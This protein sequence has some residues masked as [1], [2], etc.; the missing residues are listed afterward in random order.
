MKKFFEKE[1]VAWTF[2]TICITCAIAIGIAK[3]PKLVWD[4]AGVLS[5]STVKELKK[6]NKNWEDEYDTRIGFITADIDEG[7]ELVELAEDT[8]EELDLGD[9]DAVIAVSTE[10]NSYSLYAGDEFSTDFYKIWIEAFLEQ[11]EGKDRAKKID[12]VARELYGVLDEAFE[13][14]YD[15]QSV[16]ENPVLGYSISQGIQDLLGGVG[17]LTAGVTSTATGII[18]WVLSFI[19]SIFAKIASMGIIGTAIIVFII[20]KIIKKKD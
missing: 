16:E 12:S 14:G 8:F 6:Y 4:K 15:P 3:K 7:S 13:D 20:I 17:A 18:G 11:A 10:K 5:N 2:F 1:W 19:G 9:Y